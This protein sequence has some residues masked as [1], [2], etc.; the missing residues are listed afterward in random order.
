MMTPISTRGIEL[1]FMLKSIAQEDLLNFRVFSPHPITW[2]CQSY[3]WIWIDI[4]SDLVKDNFRASSTAYHAGHIIFTFQMFKTNHRWHPSNHKTL[5][6]HHIKIT[7]A[8]AKVKLKSKVTW[9]CTIILW[10]MSHIHKRGCIT[11]QSVRILKLF[12]GL[13]SYS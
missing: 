9:N 7:V 4:K 3:A 1:Y 5:D 13:F 12:F 10:W 2:T 6:F 8:F 11:G